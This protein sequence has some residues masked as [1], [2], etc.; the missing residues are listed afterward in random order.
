MDVGKISQNGQ[1]T[2]AHLVEVR[3]RKESGLRV[4]G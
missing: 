1:V 4:G 3:N 2:E